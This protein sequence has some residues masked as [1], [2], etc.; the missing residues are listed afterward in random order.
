MRESSPTLVRQRF[1]VRGI[2]QGVGFRP[3]VARLAAEYRLTGFVRNHSA[4]VTI[5]VEGTAGGVESFADALRSSAPVAAKIDDIE[6]RTVPLRHDASFEIAASR[7]DRGR[8]T[9]VSPDLA[10]CADCWREFHDPA[11][12]RFRYP[13]INCTNCGPRYTI[14]R[15]TPYDRP[16]TTMA[17]F[18]MCADCRREYESPT[19]RRFHAE[20]NACP[21]CGP[22]VWF[23]PGGVSR[24]DVAAEQPPAGAIRGEDA[25][26]QF[27]AAIAA[28]DVVA[29]KG[30]GG[31]H[32]ACDATSADAVARLRRRKGRIDKPFA[33]LARDLDLVE[34][35][36]HVDRSEAELLH[37][38][39]GPIV[40]LR[41]RRGSPVCREV[42][43]GNDYIGVML[44]YSPLH[45][46][47]CEHHVLV[48]TSANASE[49]PIVRT[50]AEAAE[51][52][53][54]LADAFFLHNRDI[55]VV[56]DDSVVRAVRGKELPIRR[57][58][59]YAPMPIRLPRSAPAILA[60]GGELKATF[61]ITRDDY[62]YLSPHIGDMGNLE[63]LEAYR[64]AVDHMLRLFR[65]EP[66]I[67]VCDK[68]PGYWST[69]WAKAWAAEHGALVETV[70]H[71]RAHIAG[72]A[73][74]H[75]IDWSTSVIGVSF[76]G[77]GYGDDGA[78]WG[79]EFFVGP[80]SSLRRAGH[81][82]YTWLPGGD[83]AIRHP[84]RV[85]LAHLWHAGVPWDEALPS[86]R[87]LSPVERRVLHRQLERQLRCTATS[88]MGRLFDA[89][90]SLVGVRHSITYEAQAA[91]ELEAL[92][93]SIESAEPY[94][95]SFI[96]E[97]TFQ[98][99]ASLMWRALSRDVSANRP[100]EELSSRFHRTIVDMI[101]AGSRRIGQRSN[102]RLVMLGGGVFQN[103]RLLECAVDSLARHGFDVRFPQRIPPNDGGLA[104]GQAALAMIRAGRQTAIQN[105]KEIRNR[106]R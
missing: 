65:I 14:I 15:D 56:C 96:G 20:P 10:T 47:L 4:G 34:S 12:R 73:L 66:R 87:A 9:P 46:L 78:V 3:F 13:F 27:H 36:A 31:F 104:L 79:G 30:I 59:G 80:C 106:P 2:V 70:Q 64:R 105:P 53:D 85:A 7:S 45:R 55:H 21:D 67:V 61:C 68:H 74:E 35:L 91:M 6:R 97:D 101:V 32:L 50:N 11:D 28:G 90:A 38:A 94:P 57:S 17:S 16:A 76:D 44:P 42:A 100:P 18:T 71:H 24:A 63:T 102:V 22:T 98:I 25:I 29:V 77:T 92:C 52:L 39:A 62:A 26:A 19:D 37:S 40:L 88:S 89:V 95:F 48:L 23:V 33:L 58:R 81:L 72:V 8:Q 60:A 75:G 54:H 82:A 1:E 99:D 5:E 93:G 41:R 84:C 49:E 86:V 103:V 69:R 43:P 83:A 51:R